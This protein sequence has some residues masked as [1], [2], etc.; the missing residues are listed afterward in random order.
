MNNESRLDWI[1][2][3]GSRKL[4]GTLINFKIKLWNGV[5]IFY[6]HNPVPVPLTMF[7]VTPWKMYSYICNLWSVSVQICFLTPNLSSSQVQYCKNL[8]M[9]WTMGALKTAPLNSILTVIRSWWEYQSE[10]TFSP[11]LFPEEN[12]EKLHST[13]IIAT[14]PL[15]T[16]E[17]IQP[18][19]RK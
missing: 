6:K 17:P 8:C 10:C 7:L 2:K 1:I 15:N 14:P 13:R 18:F 16:G 9:N 3:K 4:D 12:R 11:F 5:F 19:S